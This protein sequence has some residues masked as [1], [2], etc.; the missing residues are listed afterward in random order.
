MLQKP[1]CNN[2]CPSGVVGFAL[3]AAEVG[4]ISSTP[5]F[6]L[7][8]SKRRNQDNNTYYKCICRAGKRPNPGK[9]LGD[10]SSLAIIYSMY[11][12]KILKLSHKVIKLSLSV[13]H[14]SCKMQNC[15]TSLFLALIKNITYIQNPI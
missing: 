9:N 1:L 5:R 4:L 6:A 3:P 13:S 15:S 12:L 14:Q 11:M 8:G 7:L 10:Q 2:Q